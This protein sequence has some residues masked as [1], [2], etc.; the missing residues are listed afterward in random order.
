MNARIITR[1]R[2]ATFTLAALLLLGA[3]SAFGQETQSEIDDNVF[4]D[5]LPVFTRHL[6][7]EPA[8][9]QYLTEMRGMAD[10]SPF[11]FVVFV[12]TAHRLIVAGLQ[13]SVVL[14]SYVPCGEATATLRGD[15]ADFKSLVLLIGNLRL[16]KY[17]VSTVMDIIEAK[18]IPSYQLLSEAIGKSAYE[19]KRIV[20]S[21]RAKSDG[22]ANA[23]LYMFNRKYGGAMRDLMI[24]RARKGRATN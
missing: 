24:E 20:R 16:D 1:A 6:K 8:A 14:Q 12:D 15:D 7:S 18:Y 19:T 13:P 17:Q 2:Y 23:L 5:A 4:N 3:S 9:R 21:G 22:T 11:Y 10:A